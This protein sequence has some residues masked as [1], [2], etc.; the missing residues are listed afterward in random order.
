LLDQLAL[1]VAGAQFQA[2]LFFLAGAVG[3]IGEVGGFILHVGHG[4]IHFL[5]QL[6]FPIVEDVGEVSAHGIAH[7]LLTLGRLVGLEATVQLA[8]LLFC[9]GGHDVRLSLSQFPRRGGSPSGPLKTGPPRIEAGEITRTFPAALL[10]DSRNCPSCLWFAR[11]AGFP[12]PANG[13]VACSAPSARAAA[14]LNLSMSWPCWRAPMNCRPPAMTSFTWRSA[15]RTSPPP[16]PSLLPAR[17]HWPPGRPATP[18]PAAC[19]NCARPW[20]A[21]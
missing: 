9:F 18:R 2:E 21:T 20:L 6:Q 7:V 13:E 3:R 11:I 1:T 15:S 17:P 10:P 19:R 14:P 5:H 4:A 8:L 12:H 16:N